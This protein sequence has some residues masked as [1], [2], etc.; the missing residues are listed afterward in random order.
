MPVT[1]HNIVFEPS[2]EIADKSNIK[3]FMNNNGIL[4]YALLIRKSS[5]NIEWYWDAD[6]GDLSSLDNPEAIGALSKAL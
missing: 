4:D 3:R 1:N 2:A 6:V 5:D